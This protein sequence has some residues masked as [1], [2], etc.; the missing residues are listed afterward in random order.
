[1]IECEI[2]HPP[3]RDP[4][5]KPLETKTIKI[6]TYQ[7][8]RAH[9]AQYFGPKSSTKRNDGKADI[10]LKFDGLSFNA[11]KTVMREASELFEKE[12]A[13][14]K[15]KQTKGSKNPKTC[16]YDFNTTNVLPKGCKTEILDKV[17]D[18]AYTGRLP[19]YPAKEFMD[20]LTVAIA[21]Q[22]REALDAYYKQFNH[23]FR[24][25]FRTVS[26]KI[27]ASLL[28]LSQKI[29]KSN[30]KS[31]C[32]EHLEN[33]FDGTCKYLL[34]EPVDK[35]I[36]DKDFLQDMSADGMEAF[37]DR[38]DLAKPEEENKVASCIFC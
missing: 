9:F 29:Q 10:V 2:T 7:C 36:S 11:H 23:I 5:F 21:L 30:Q 20:F 38:D 32:A 8:R 13:F 26:T 27:A 4:Y 37:L 1:M 15:T 31:G 19:N 34:K 35:L 6:R 16:E 18:F 12:P 17:I 33:L 28:T 24:G 14:Q 22:F 3:K 25:G